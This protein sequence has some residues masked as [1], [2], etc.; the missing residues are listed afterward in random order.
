MSDNRKSSPPANISAELAEQDREQQMRHLQG[1]HW[2]TPRK[3]VLTRKA[4]PED[5][6]MR[7]KQGDARE[8][9]GFEYRKR[10]RDWK[11]EFRARGR[12]PG[13]VIE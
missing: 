2:G 9:A 5:Q 10:S 13:E 4:T 8:Q 12:Q 6:A 3:G 1:A 7:G 11:R